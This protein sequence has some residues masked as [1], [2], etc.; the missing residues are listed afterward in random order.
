ADPGADASGIANVGYEIS[1]GGSW[2]PV[3]DNWSTT[4]V[5]DGVYDIHVV[6]TDR[7][8]NTTISSPVSGR[9]V[10]NTAPSTSDNA[11]AD[12]Q[13]SDVTVS[14]SASDS[15]SG[16]SVTEYSVD[17]GGFQAGSSVTIAAPADGSNDGTH[18]ISYFSAD[19]A[20]NI[21]ATKSTTVEIDATPP[22][23]PDCSADDY[24]TG[25]ETLSAT[26]GASLSGI[27]SVTFE[28]ADE[29][30][31]RTSPPPGTW[32]TIEI[33]TTP[34]Y[35]VGWNTTAVADGA[36]DLRVVI[37]NNA[38]NSTI[39]Y[40]DSRVIDNTAPVA[41]VGAPGA[42]SL[43]S[44]NV[45]FA[46]TAGDDNPIASVE[47]LVDG[48]SL[49]SVSSPPFRT[50]WDT[51]GHSDGGATLQVVVTDIAG[52]S[53][54]S[55]SSGVT[56]DNNGPSPSLG[57]PGPG[58]SGN[59][60]LNASS[61]GDTVRV[62]IQR[63]P[64]GGNTWTTIGSPT[65]APFSVSFDST[66]LVDGSYDLRAV[67]TDQ[68]GHVGTSA[69][70]TTRVDNAAPAASLTSP[71]AGATIGGPAVQLTAAASDSTSG[72]ASVRFQFRPTGGGGFNDIADDNS[73]PYAVSWDATTLATGSYDLRVVATDA[74]GN[75]TT[76]AAVT[77]SIDSTAPI[78][79]LDDP[80]S[81][82]LSGAVTLTATTSGS[83]AARVTFERSPA[84]A[85][86]WTAI[87]TDLGA[88]WSGSFDTTGVADG[89][90]DLRAVAADALGN[91]GTSVRSGIRIDNGA[92]RIVSSTPAD[93]AVVATADAIVL[94]ASEALAAIDGA[95]LD[96]AGVVAPIL[97][98][99]QA[100][101]PVGT[102]GLGAHTLAGTL[103]DGS[104][105]T[106]AFQVHFTVWAG[107]GAGGV[108]VEENAP[109]DRSTTVTAPDS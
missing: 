76:T 30:A 82:T 6:A 5:A 73:A 64:A 8:G 70:V 51:T 38:G 102:L 17:G 100:T 50:T 15:G 67:A 58:V 75:V 86:N 13:S 33:D 98:G 43:I 37:E 45:T 11:P 10:D 63:S 59:V 66:L 65:S 23:C 46:A 26:P 55:G 34:P 72:V 19:V 103:R 25:T 47:F 48:Q 104:G 35:S 22:V 21:E 57:N 83:P 18:T 107:G 16:V 53:T 69:I 109:R 52:N 77:V 101:Y 60:T 28:Y 93:G 99:A 79:V 91:E 41:G 108:G 31:P 54:T 106:R 96:G 88:P 49:A 95:T 42:G 68:S 89:L 92:P 71:N 14:L 87:S 97:S 80:G 36:Y 85:S 12:Y 4:S 44:G 32:Q 20:G 1:S 94:V 90:Y 27:K 105:K 3:A 24:L 7:A 40:L 2:T 56:I 78:V 39:T 84:G 29:G 9:R 81:A 61:D 74:A 62:D